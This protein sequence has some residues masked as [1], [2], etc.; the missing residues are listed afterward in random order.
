MKWLNELSVPETVGL[1]VLASVVLNYLFFCGLAW[2][3]G[4]GSSA[5]I[6]AS[7]NS[8]KASK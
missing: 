1:V 8:K 4:A 6:A 5:G 3:I 2:A 7:K